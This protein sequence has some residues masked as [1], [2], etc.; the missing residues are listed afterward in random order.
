MQR[1]SSTPIK[2][3]IMHDQRDDSTNLG[4]RAFT[5]GLIQLAQH[6]LPSAEVRTLYINQ[7]FK[8]FFDKLE[9]S[10]GNKIEVFEK[11]VRRY[12]L[13]GILLEK[14]RNYK[15]VWKYLE[16]GANYL[17]SLIQQKPSNI[18]LRMLNKLF[19][20]QVINQ[21]VFST[22]KKA[23]LLIM[24]GHAIVRDCFAD[25]LFVLLFYSNVAKRLNKFVAAVNQTVKVQGPLLCALVK[26]TYNELDYIAARDTGSKERLIK[27][28]VV[29]EKVHLSS[30]A[31]FFL[32]I[33]S[34]DEIER[35]ISEEGITEGSIGLIIRDENNP[36][37]KLWAKIINQIQERFKKRVIYVTTS[38]VEDMNFIKGVS[39]FIPLRYLKN[40]YDYNEMI[41]IFKRLELIIS[42][43]Y[44]GAIFS[45]LANT[46]LVPIITNG[47]KT[48]WLFEFFD[49]PIQVLDLITAANQERLIETV[50]ETYQNYDKC[51]ES[52]S[53]ALPGL[54][55][56]SMHNFPDIADLGLQKAK[57]R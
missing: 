21:D 41:E 12:L 47:E 29:P 16:K 13:M 44:H 18:F 46:P 19:V 52:L 39:K 1:N 11:W 35:I 26:K 14:V 36:D 2:V 48:K 56:Y 4:T 25:R 33:K 31:A 53:R 8:Y 27:I 42:D 51:R 9:R 37:Y 22:I 3:I 45:I 24:N 17:N 57:G 40:E 10:S 50:R 20:F 15:T 6:N 38:K 32:Q 49:Y 54:R 5:T 28:G 7:D 43:R 30:D 34:S 55:Q 23:D